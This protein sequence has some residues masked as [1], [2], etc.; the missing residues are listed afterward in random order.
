MAELGL[1]ERHPRGATL[2]APEEPP[3]RIFQSHLHVLQLAGGEA[4]WS[5]PYISL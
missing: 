3:L 5:R 4:P 1:H 2:I